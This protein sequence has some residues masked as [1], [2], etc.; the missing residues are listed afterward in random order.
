MY[1]YVVLKK[2]KKIVSRGL[3]MKK[4]LYFTTLF[5]STSIIFGAGPSGS[6]KPAIRNRV[7][8]EKKRKPL[9]INKHTYRRPNKPWFIN[10]QE[11]NASLVNP[12]VIAGVGCVLTGTM[13]Y[14][15]RTAV[16]DFLCDVFYY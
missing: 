3:I 9:A 2:N 6:D 13:L 5:I 16:A 1:S 7:V 11:N 4:L 14:V 10:P 8:K 12:C 15:Q